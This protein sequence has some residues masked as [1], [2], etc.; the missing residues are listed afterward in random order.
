M[1]EELLTLHGKVIASYGTRC[2]ADGKPGVFYGL[3]H[4]GVGEYIFITN[5]GYRSPIKL[6]RTNWY[7]RMTLMY[8]A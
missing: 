6:F 2:H 3:K 5:S 1:V 8:Y 4:L 7:S